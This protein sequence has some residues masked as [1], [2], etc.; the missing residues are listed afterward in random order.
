M[1]EAQGLLQRPQQNAKRRRLV[2]TPQPQRPALVRP[3][4]LRIPLVAE[5]GY[6]LQLVDASYDLQVPMIY[7]EGGFAGLVLGDL[8]GSGPDPRR[9]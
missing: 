5:R 6:H 8:G 1:Q 3:L 9:W 2:L 4:G 7:R